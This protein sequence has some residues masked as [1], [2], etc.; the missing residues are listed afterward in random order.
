MIKYKLF[1]LL[2]LMMFAIG[3]SK[4]ELYTYPSSLSDKAQITAIRVLNDAGEDVVMDYTID[5]AT[6]TVTVKANADASLNKLFPTATVSEGVVVEPVMGNYTDFSLP[7][8]YTLIAGDR[9]TK[10]NWTITVTH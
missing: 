7:V 1:L 2:A 5:E 9:T 3:C 4:D 6:S 8:T 10:R